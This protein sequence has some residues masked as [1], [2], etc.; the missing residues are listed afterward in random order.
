MWF[1]MYYDLIN[2]V[3]V[4]I[5]FHTSV[6]QECSCIVHMY[7]CTQSLSCADVQVVT[8]AQ[9]APWLQLSLN[10]G[11]KTHSSFSWNEAL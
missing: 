4:W 11:K 9:V 2:M 10:L 3:D 7:W 1:F 8:V 6:V 5:Y